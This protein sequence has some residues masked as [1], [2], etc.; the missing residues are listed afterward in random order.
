MG[1]HVDPYRRYLHYPHATDGAAKSSQH[2]DLSDFYTGAENEGVCREVTR[3]LTAFQ[4][5]VYYGQR[6]Y[7]ACPAWRDELTVQSPDG[8]PAP[9]RFAI[10]VH[11]FERRGG[12]AGRYLGFVSLRPPGFVPRDRGEGDSAFNYIIDAELTAP[13]HMQRPRYHVLNTTAASARL[14][15]VPFRSSV[16][17]CPGPNA[18]RGSTCAHLAVSQALHLIMG[19]FACRPISQIE[20]DWHLWR[21]TAAPTR[22]DWVA[23]P[24]SQSIGKM[25]RRG[26]NLREAL[27]VVRASCNGGGYRMAVE[28]R[29]DP[30]GLSL[31]IAE[32]NRA[33][34]YLTDSLANGLPVVA[35][36]RTDHLLPPA[37][38]R[39][40]EAE[41]ERDPSGDT[42][43]RLRAPH[44]VLVLGMHLL[45][46]GEEAWPEYGLAW[47]EP[48]VI[49]LED[50]KGETGAGESRE[51]REDRAELPGRVIIHDTLTKGPFYECLIS[52]F[53][54]AAEAAYRDSQGLDDGECRGVHLLALGPRELSLGVPELREYAEKTL[55]TYLVGLREK[56]PVPSPALETLRAYM[57]ACDLSPGETSSPDQWRLVCRFTGSTEVDTRY[58]GMRPEVEESPTSTAPYFWAVEIRHP[59]ARRKRPANLFMAP[60]E[61]APAMVLVW[62][63][64]QEDADTAVATA[65]ALEGL[66]PLRI[67]HFPPPSPCQDSQM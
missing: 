2:V 37:K 59:R 14:G 24:E 55:K 10:R 44:C 56:D 51:Q 50:E 31:S 26:A 43:K 63:S 45:H 52:D 32:K 60:A 30:A 22:P 3:L 13:K 15:V 21:A 16:Y 28:P 38:R 49:P 35:V 46:S 48:G 40:M 5:E 53:L 20:F 1:E 17:S 7:A 42:A 54:N 11:L 6:H 33:A 65:R 29:E 57:G 8:E 66:P 67:L 39:E 19:R 23:A 9:R 58:R 4:T 25:G 12:E 34:R 64:G 61:L 27:A 47:R 62:E 41:V 36:V 18:D